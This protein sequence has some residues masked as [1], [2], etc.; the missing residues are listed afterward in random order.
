MHKVGC[1]LND[2]MDFGVLLLNNGPEEGEDYIGF[3]RPLTLMPGTSSP[4]STTIT[5]VNDILYEP[6]KEVFVIQMELAVE[7]PFTRVHLSPPDGIT[8]G[9][10]DDEG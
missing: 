9:I 10:L 6:Y 7:S 3:R 5:I 4:N 2:F 1:S 8:L